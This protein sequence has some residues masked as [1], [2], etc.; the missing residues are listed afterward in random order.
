MWPSYSLFEP[1]IWQRRVVIPLVAYIV[2]RTM[3][4]WR[5]FPPL[6]MGLL[7]ECWNEGAICS[8]VIGIII[9]VMTAPPSP[10]STPVWCHPVHTTTVNDV[11]G[12]RKN[13]GGLSHLYTFVRLCTIMY[14]KVSDFRRSMS[15]CLDDAI[16]G[17]TVY[18]QRA[19]VLFELRVAI[20]G[21]LST[22]VIFDEFPKNPAKDSRVVPPE[23][24]A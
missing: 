19:G 21:T 8:V 3:S 12:P 18:I 9:I 24:V 14:M 22:S 5:R 7:H 11:K 10:Y 13:L 15:S 23:D 2:G 20:Q 17:E 4:I 6:V 1:F 16:K